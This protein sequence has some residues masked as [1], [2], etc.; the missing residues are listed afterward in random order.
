MNGDKTLADCVAK[1]AGGPAFPLDATAAIRHAQHVTESAGDRGDAPFIAALLD[2]AGM[3]KR[4]EFA[5]AAMQ[6][7]CADP[8][9]GI[10]PTLIARDA[11]AI[12]DAML[13]VR[14]E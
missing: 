6:G 1:F 4:D 2:A 8:T 9:S 11:Y 13:K 7:I 5:K 12:A 14:S 10:T 3:T